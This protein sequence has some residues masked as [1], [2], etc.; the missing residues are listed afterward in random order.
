QVLDT[1]CG[2]GRDSATLAALDCTVTSL[3]RHDVLFALL[4]D[5]RA[6]AQT[7]PP[8][9]LAAWRDL[10]HADA[11]DWL[12][13]APDRVFDII[14][15]DPMFDAPRRKARPQKA[16]AW[17]HELVG[18]DTDVASLLERARERAAR[19]VVVKQ[20][21]RATSIARPDRQVEGKAIR[22]DIYLS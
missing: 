4:D 11:C 13:Q 9:W 21:A 7:A 10:I 15:I 2:L 16:L 3:E 6:R 1:T 14:Y 20:H 18:T 5:A 12:A 17:M 22:F 8:V 19:Q